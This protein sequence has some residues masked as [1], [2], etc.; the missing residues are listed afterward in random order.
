[1]VRAVSRTSIIAIVA[2]LAVAGSVFARGWTPSVPDDAGA[3][4]V[5][6]TVLTGEIPPDV[7]D[8]VDVATVPLTPSGQECLDPIDRPAG[9]LSLCWEAHR[10]P[11]DAD[12]SQ[13]YYV[14]RVY[15]AF[16][17]STDGGVRWASIRADLVG[18]PSNNV[19]RGWPQGA[20][21]GTCALVDSSLGD[22]STE[23]EMLCGRT[24]G[25]TDHD[26]WSHRVTWVCV[27]CLIPDHTDHSIV[28]RE[29]VAMREGSIPVWEL[30]ADIGS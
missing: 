27:G 12:P 11:N 3:T 13:D 20:F 5:A 22:G 1:L 24:I 4:P 23:P 18:E 6:R 29:L 28:L 21:D 19:L 9:T 15:G 30:F 8:G 16:G 26:T 17:G 14:L 7:T 2:V 10:S 25:A